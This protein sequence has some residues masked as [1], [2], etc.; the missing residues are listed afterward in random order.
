MSMSEINKPTKK[1]TN[2]AYKYFIS[3][4]KKLSSL[5]LLEIYL[6]KLF[7]SHYNF[8]LIFCSIFLHIRTVIQLFSWMLDNCYIFQFLLLM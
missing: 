1:Q 8:V 2:T 7:C 5:F 6:L 3:A 4:M